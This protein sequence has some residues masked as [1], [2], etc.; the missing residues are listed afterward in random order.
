MENKNELPQD[1]YNNAK[2]SIDELKQFE[3]L[4]ELSDEELEEISDQLFDLA[5][6]S[7]GVIKDI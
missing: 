3:E 7:L 2:L 5:I 6:V 4:K 1:Y